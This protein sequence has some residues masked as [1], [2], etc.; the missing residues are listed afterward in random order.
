MNLV[1]L[2][3]LLVVSEIMLVVVFLLKNSVCGF[4][5]ILMCLRLKK[6]FWMMWFCL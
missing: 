1:L 4:F 3:G 6:F 5:R 2:F